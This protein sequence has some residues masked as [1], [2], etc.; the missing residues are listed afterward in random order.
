MAWDANNAGQR[1]L[2]KPR[3][4]AKCLGILERQ[5]WQLSTPRGTI[6]VTRIGNSVPYAIT[7]LTE[8][9]A[10]SQTGGAQ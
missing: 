9:I 7:A 10:A 3:E 1:L 2:L 5:L 6:P 8:W 4:A